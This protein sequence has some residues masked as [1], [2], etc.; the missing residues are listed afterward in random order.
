MPRFESVQARGMYGGGRGLRFG[1]IAVALLFFSL[2]RPSACAGAVWSQQ[3]QPAV[4]IDPA[5]IT[6]PAGDEFVVNVAVEGVQ[7]A[8]AFELVVRYDPALVQVEEVELG[9]FLAVEGRTVVPLGTSINPIS[10]EARAGALTVGSGT[11]ASGSGVLVT[12]RVTALR[13]GEG[14]LEL[15]NV[16]LV[17]TE[18][19]LIPTTVSGGRV[20]FTG[21]VV[22]PTNTP[23]PATAIPEPS[24]TPQVTGT[25]ESPA[26]SEAQPSPPPVQAT[27]TEQVG[28]ETT[29]I[30][31]ATITLPETPTPGVPTLSPDEIET[32]IV[33]AATATG[34]ALHAAMA[35]GTITPRPIPSVT[36]RPRFTTAPVAA[37]T[38]VAAATGSPAATPQASSGT[39][40]V[41]APILIG[42]GALAAGAGGLLY[43]SGARR[44]SRGRP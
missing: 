7:E 23:A 2:L 32:Q 39:R 1:G 19:E 41:V 33:M 40:D 44:R 24:A 18:A 17:N 29:P 34:E 20:I 16:R 21:G 5:E 42:A 26:T 38:P 3:T 28:T 13:G 4:F 11:G 22:V 30:P 8:G 25:S 35:S 14:S 27:M 10:G 12:L 15:T 36:A 6:R 37:V 31:G 43:W 9:P